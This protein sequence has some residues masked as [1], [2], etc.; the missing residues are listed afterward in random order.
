MQRACRLFLV[1]GAM[2]AAGVGFL[3]QFAEGEREESRGEDGREPPP[4]GPCAPSVKGRSRSVVFVD[5]HDFAGN[6]TVGGETLVARS[7]RDAVVSCG[8]NVS[9]LSTAEFQ[10]SELRH[11]RLVIGNG[12]WFLRTDGKGGGPSRLPVAS[13]RLPLCRLRAL[14]FW[15]RIEKAGVFQGRRADLRQYVT[16]HAVRCS[17][18]TLLGFYTGVP[19]PLPNPGRGKV[20]LMWGKRGKYLSPRKELLAALVQA[21]WEV[22]CTCSARGTFRGKP[23]EC[24]LPEGVVDH[25]SL[26]VT[27]WR[28]LLRRAAF[29]LGLGDPLLSPSPVEALAHGAT[30]LLPRFNSKDSVCG[31]LP[32][33]PRG[34]RSPLP[35]QETQHD[36]LAPV[37][38]PYVRIVSLDD[39]A[40]VLQA[41]EL[42]FKERFASHIPVAYTWEAHRQR[43]ETMLEDDSICGGDGVDGGWDTRRVPRSDMHRTADARRGNSLE[44]ARRQRSSGSTLAARKRI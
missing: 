41:A 14:Y 25:G 1:T 12:E 36:G 19:N 7:M 11:A 31:T 39:T 27:D 28:G 44:G 18:N 35:P 21:G 4:P 16:P 32:Q 15:G 10:T 6:G 17:R 43:V 8:F 24:D 38:P 23:E 20:A 9:S 29:I 22:H 30:V 2:A 5:F 40:G 33:V 26:N 34:K 13:G 37:G 42:A 3:W